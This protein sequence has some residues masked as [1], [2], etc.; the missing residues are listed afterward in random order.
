MFWV[1]HNKK[2][3]ATLHKAFCESCNAGM[4]LSGAVDQSG[5]WEGPFEDIDEAKAS[6][7]VALIPCRKCRPDRDW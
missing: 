7:E 3:K 2:G 5:K 4:G 1:Y 6:T